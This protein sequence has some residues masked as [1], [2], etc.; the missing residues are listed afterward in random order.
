MCNKSSWIVYNFSVF[1]VKWRMAWELYLHCAQLPMAPSKKIQQFPSF[2]NFHDAVEQLAI[3]FPTC[4]LPGLV[5]SVE[6]LSLRPSA[7]FPEVLLES[8]CVGADCKVDL[9]AK[10]D[11]IPGEL[12]YG[13]A[14][15]RFEA[16]TGEDRGEGLW[17]NRP[18][19]AASLGENCG[20]NLAPCLSCAP[21]SVPSYWE[22][23]A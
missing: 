23:S 16:G 17:E 4:A 22:A 21:A 6:S 8:P 1:D 11:D 14:N 9:R 19:P 10:G 12:G 15:V 18:R 5:P 13:F 3:Y 2:R 20:V 7:G